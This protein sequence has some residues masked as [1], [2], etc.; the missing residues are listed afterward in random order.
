MDI[1]THIQ[2]PSKRVF[3]LDWL[4]ITAKDPFG[5]FS[6][7][8]FKKEIHSTCKRF[9]AVYVR[10]IRSYE[11]VYFVFMGKV[12]IGEVSARPKSSIIKPLIIFKI[13]NELLYRQELYSTIELFLKGFKVRFRGYSRVDIACDY[14]RTDFTDNFVKN[15]IDKK[16]LHLG[17]KKG[18]RYEYYTK[19]NDG[20]RFTTKE[21]QADIQLSSYDKTNE[22]KE[23]SGKHY[24]SEAWRK[25][26]I[27]AVTIAPKNPKRETHTAY[28]TSVQRIEVR[29]KGAEF[30]RLKHHVPNE[31]GEAQTNDLGL[32]FL[33]RIQDQ[34]V[35]SWMFGEFSENFLGWRMPKRKDTKKSRM[36]KVKCFTHRQ[37]KD[38]K[39]IRDRRAKTALN[40]VTR[41]KRTIKTLIRNAVF[42]TGDFSCWVKSLA[43]FAKEHHLENFLFEK[44]DYWFREFEAESPLF[45]SKEE[46]LGEYEK[47]LESLQ[48]QWKG[49]TYKAT[50]HTQTIKDLEFIQKVEKVEENLKDEC[51]EQSIKNTIFA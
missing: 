12:K 27:N 36:D 6:G 28:F 38:T 49:E 39:L 44:V 34:T 45:W 50:G 43:N 3:F 14:V 29:V 15:L 26:G 19:G 37:C 22:I 11:R 13:E 20:F 46:F 10:E 16:N 1:K 41:S 40:K 32:K 9:K 30:M 31:D 23:V 7:G 5:V 18:F 48:N 4:A 33:K 51:L 42:E 24:I 8:N 35:L 2:I 47:E 21:G 17:R 25:N